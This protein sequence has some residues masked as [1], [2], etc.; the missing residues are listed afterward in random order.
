MLGA[1]RKAPSRLLLVAAGGAAL[2]ASCGQQLESSAASGL[3]TVRPMINFG[4]IDTQDRYAYV[5]LVAIYEKN[6][7]V[8]YCSGS[9]IAPTVVLTAGH[10]TEEA[11]NTFDYARV[12]FGHDLTEEYPLTWANN[13]AGTGGYLGEMIPH[14]EYA[15]FAGFPN[16]HD[17]GLIILEEPVP[18]SVVASYPELAPLGY[19]DDLAIRRGRQDVQFVTVGYG[20]TSRKPT[21][22]FDDYRRFGIVTLTNLRSAN[23]DG[24]NLMTSNNPGLGGGGTGGNCSG[25]SGGPILHAGDTIVAVNS[26]GIAPHCKGNDYAYRVDIADSLDW[27]DAVLDEEGIALP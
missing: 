4:Q 23:T 7:L 25:D 26:F 1:Q 11:G 27:I 16:T 3:A 20:L 18:T 2:L 8:G 21:Y 10:C 6:T 17:I 24:Y 14:P 22:T 9:L 19:L 5:G 12:Y 13:E 15:D